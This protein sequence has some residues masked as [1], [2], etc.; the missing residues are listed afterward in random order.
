VRT[1]PARNVSS[2]IDS[3]VLTAYQRPGMS[4]RAARAIDA[5]DCAVEAGVGAAKHRHSRREVL[6][7]NLDGE[8]LEHFVVK[9]L[10]ETLKDGAEERVTNHKPRPP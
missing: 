3:R 8:E 1:S 4:L 2:R 6:S 9:V 10:A 5:P 7:H